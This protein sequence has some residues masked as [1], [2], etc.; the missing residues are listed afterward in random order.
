[1]SSQLG[2]VEVEL[3]LVSQG[4]AQK[5]N[6]IMV[7]CI[8]GGRLGIAFALCAR[9]AELEVSGVPVSR[10]GGR[11][12]LNRPPRLFWLSLSARFRKQ[13]LRILSCC[14]VVPCA[15]ISCFHG[16]AVFLYCIPHDTM[17]DRQPLGDLFICMLFYKDFCF[18]RMNGRGVVCVLI[19]A[20]VWGVGCKTGGFGQEREGDRC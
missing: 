13:R 14:R 15:Y 5:K 16:R 17:N 3:S 18:H 8:G 19:L 2:R 11:L 4:G 9:A 10:Q 12:L 6:L 20:C 7:S 1:M